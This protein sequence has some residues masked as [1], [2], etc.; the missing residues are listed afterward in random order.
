MGYLQWNFTN[1]IQIFG[2]GRSLYTFTSNWLV[3]Y[4]FFAYFVIIV[5][6]QVI[7]LIEN[8]LQVNNSKYLFCSLKLFKKTFIIT[9]F[10]LLCCYKVVSI[11]PNYMLFI[12]DSVESEWY[13]MYQMEST[14]LC[15]LHAHV[16]TCLVCLCARANM[17]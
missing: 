16:P 8:Q 6:L 13:L 15:A 12:L 4:E 11:V 9:K 3:V 2:E 17:P 1:L 10:I 5:Q 7:I 14:K